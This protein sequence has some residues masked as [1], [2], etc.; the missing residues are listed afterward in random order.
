[1]TAGSPNFNPAAWERAVARLRRDL[2]LLTQR[3]A[4]AALRAVG[5]DRPRALNRLD[6]YLCA[7]ETGLLTP[8][9]DCP[10]VAVRLTVHLA[11]AG[12]DDVAPLGCSRCGA[13]VQLTARPGERICT[14]CAVRQ[15]RFVCAH[16]HTPMTTR[17]ARRLPEGPICLRCYAKH[18]L[19]HRRCS[20]C[21][22]MRYPVRRLP[23]GGVLCQRCAPRRQHVCSRCGQTRPAQCITDDGPICNNC[24]R[25]VKLSWTCALCG[26]VRIRQ[27]NTVVGPHVCA[28]CRGTRLRNAS[29]A[30][31]QPLRRNAPGGA[32]RAN[33]VCT[34]C[35]KVRPVGHRWPAGPVC[36][37]CAER[38][39]SYPAQCAHCQQI[40]V[41]TALDDTGQRICGPCAGWPVDYLCHRCGEPGIKS[42]GLC[43]RCIT[44]QR[45]QTALAGPDGE[46]VEQ[47]RPLVDALVSAPD[48]RSVAVWLGRS[49]AATMLTELAAQGEPITHETLDAVSP[50]PHADYIREILVRTA[51]LEPRNEYHDRLVLWLDQYL[52][53]IG[54]DHARLL[55]AYAQWCLLH[56]ARRR[57]GPMTRPMADRIRTQVRV[58]HE[59]VTR[60]ETDGHTLNTVGQD[61]GRQLVGPWHDT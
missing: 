51:I 17:P 3:D 8:V 55:R 25:R 47:L 43:S 6:R 59:F 15:Q 39:R 61:L 5:A 28:S 35:G 27:R 36:K 10:A 26:V 4:A 58:A 19:S 29:G 9:S 44:R 33:S 24:Y 30:N 37:S 2:P 13:Q 46:V 11:A 18:P 40:K 48:P 54:D 38:S 14:R 45:L 56:R 12:H 50:S 42:R 31:E 7:H 32:A 16:C 41:L 20:N 49:A 23:D 60:V 53:G 22:R 1:M 52:A 34:F 21:D 57:K